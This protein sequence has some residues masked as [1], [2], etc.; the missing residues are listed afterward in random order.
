MHR[1]LAVPLLLFLSLSAHAQQPASAS[2]EQQL[3]AYRATAMQFG[4]QLRG[5][6]Q[7]AI[8]SGGPMEAVEV[9]QL[10]APQIASELSVQSG[11]QIHRT[12]L[13]ARARPADAWE[14]GVL[15][16]FEV[17]KAEGVP[18]A[19]IEHY[20]VLEV[21]GKP[22]LRYMKAIPAEAACLACHGSQVDP[23]LQ[24]HIRQLYPSDLALGYAEGD[25]RGAFSI[26]ASAP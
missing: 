23:Q 22:T 8:Q 7:S 4:Q 12:S 17:R 24:A 1:T 9:C 6:L 16:G 15:E 26:S 25:I 21:E 11:W 10:R 20:E 3:A 18:I 5:E 13:K 19:Q 14:T 2:V